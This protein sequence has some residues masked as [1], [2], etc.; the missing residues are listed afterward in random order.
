MRSAPH[1]LR[2]RMTYVALALGTIAIGLIVHWRGSTLAPA[3]R[4][5]LGDA[6]WA[7]MIFWWLSALVPR[8]KLLARAGIA[9][10]V[11]VWV[12]FS[13]LYH[14]A[15]LDRIRGTVIGHL[16]LGSGF[17][18][19]DLAAYTLGVLGAAWLDR[20]VTSSSAHHRA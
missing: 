3:L 20:L 19:R 5:V 17:D 9:F 7:A 14:A 18:P 12:E 11:C 4:D 6:L 1:L 10:G 15:G 2:T 16:I 8:A 13:Q